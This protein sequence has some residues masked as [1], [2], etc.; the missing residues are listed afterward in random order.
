MAKELW[1]CEKKEAINGKPI[2][3]PISKVTKGKIKPPNIVVI[4]KGDLEEFNVVLEIL[5]ADGF[6]LVDT[7]H[8]QQDEFF[9]SYTATLINLD[10]GKHYGIRGRLTSSGNSAIH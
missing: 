10:G 6:D 9:S 4:E 3:S 2:F 8:K 7:A 5:I 1:V